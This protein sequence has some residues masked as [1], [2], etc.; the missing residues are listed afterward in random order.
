MRTLLRNKVTTP[1]FICLGKFVHKRTTLKKITIDSHG[2]KRGYFREIENGHKTHFKAILHQQPD[3]ITNEM[4]W[5]W[6]VHRRIAGLL[7]GHFGDYFVS[8]ITSV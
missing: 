6:N 7:D 2:R 3:V 1:P 5:C 4:V 8:D